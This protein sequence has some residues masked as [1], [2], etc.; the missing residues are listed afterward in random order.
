M[1]HLLAS[2][3]GAEEGRE[4]STWY[5]LFEHVHDYSKEYVAEIGACTNMVTNSSR[6]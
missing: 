6:E 1:L 3:P 4:K 2:F 5:T